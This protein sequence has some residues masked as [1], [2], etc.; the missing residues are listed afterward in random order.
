M[1]NLELAYLAVEVAD[2]D[3]VGAVLTDVVGLMRGE[4]VGDAHTW[5]NDDRAQRMIL[6]PGPAND[7]AAV[8]LEAPSAGD[9]AAI[10]ERLRYM[11]YEVHEGSGADRG[12]RKVEQLWH[13]ASPWGVR[14]ELVVG[15]QQTATPAKTALMP[16]GFVTDGVG[17]GHCVFFVGDLDEAHRFTVDGLGF[18]Q[19][20]SLSFEVAPGVAVHGRFYHANPRHH[21][22]A[23]VQPPMLPPIKLHHV[24][25]EVNDQDDVGHAFDRAFAAGVPIANG[26]GRHPN[27]R[28][29]SFYLETPAGFQVEVGYGGRLVGP[30]WDDDIR[31]DRI[32]AWGHQPVV[33]A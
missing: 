32:S 14:F 24:M 3:A 16:S 4:D 27:D 19:S 11:G 8:G 15:H 7:V 26:I 5:R 10:V 22:I 25:V 21:T 23:L 18:R 6:H 20:D 12:S 9:L 13:V 28:M 30:E 1:N 17:F 31:Y 33:R 29:I 2:L